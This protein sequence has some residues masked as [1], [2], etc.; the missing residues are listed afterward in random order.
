VARKEGLEMARSDE[1]LGLLA[2]ATKKLLSPRPFPSEIQEMGTL[3]QRRT[4][5]AELDQIYED[6]IAELSSWGPIAS[7]RNSRRALLRGWLQNPCSSPERPFGAPPRRM[8]AYLACKEKRH[9]DFVAM[10]RQGD[11]CE[12]RAEALRARF[13]GYLAEQDT[14]WCVASMQQEGRRHAWVAVFA[15]VTNGSEEWRVEKTYDPWADHETPFRQWAWG[16]GAATR[17]RKR[18][19]KIALGEESGAARTEGVDQRTA[20]ALDI[21]R[22]PPLNHIKMKSENLIPRVLAVVAGLFCWLG[23]LLFVAPTMPVGHVGVGWCV[24]APVIW[25]GVNVLVLVLL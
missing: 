20:F 11:S 21:T 13:E 19:W 15:R 8:S 23:T 9:R 7:F 16:G 3:E 5:E 24:V 25:E 6:L 22:A 4:L 10:V 12:Q 1:D 18:T 17:R 2:E 14:R